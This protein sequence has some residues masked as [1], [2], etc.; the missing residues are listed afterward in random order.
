M[1]ASPQPERLQEQVEAASLDDS[2]L[3][4]NREL[5]LLEFQKRVLEE[6]Q[7]PRLPLLERLKFLAIVSSNL[8]EF[9]MV[10][11]AGLLDQVAAGVWEPSSGDLSPAEQL[12]AIRLEI[13]SLLEES[14]K[15]LRDDVIPG[16]DE[17]G[18]RILPYGSLTKTQRDAADAY[19]AEHV[20]PVLTPLAF[21]PS[22]PFPHISNLS[23]NLAVVI[24]HPDQSERF[25]RVKVPDTLPQFVRV[26]PKTSKKTSYIWLEELISANLELLFPGTRIIEAHPFHVTRDADIAIQELEADDLLEVIAEGVRQRRFGSVVRLTVHDDM[27]EKILTILKNNLEIHANGVYRLNG[28]LALNRLM[29]LYGIDRPDLKDSPMLPKFPAAFDG[30]DHDE[31]LFAVVAREDILLHHP[32]DSF[33]PLIDF[34]RQAARDPQVL[35]I[36]MTLYRVGKNSPVVEALLEAMQNGKQVAVLVELKARFDEESNISW[37]RALEEEGVHVV[38]GLVGLKIHSKVA[39]VVRQEGNQV[40]RYVHLS[41]GN[42][43]AV[44]ANLYTDLG[45]LTC[46]TELAADVTQL[47]NYLTGY[48]AEHHYRKLLVAPVGL[49]ERLQEMIER[50]ISIQESGGQGHLIFKTNGLADKA[51]MQLLYRA[52]RAGVRCDLLVRGVCCLRPGVPGVSEN[53]RVVSVVGRFLEHSRAY[54]FRNG[55]NEELYIGSADIMRRNLTYRVETVFPILRPDLIRYVRDEVLNTA[56]ADNQ[57]ARVMQPHGGYARVIPLA[58]ELPIDSQA[59]MAQRTRS[60]G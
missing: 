19:F 57:K 56:L 34:L 12:R 58:G 5:S 44:T 45:L 24:R 30:S 36:K 21:D 8:N 31:N 17:A 60:A 48:A 28:P 53:I 6:A 59:L 42:Y 47:F 39:L 10:R 2:A 3:Y 1:A 4:V 43:N 52:S 18:V 35:A 27:P 38:Y 54:Y 51:L 23:L 29:S 11:V 20:F 40:R 15:C 25:A 55:G 46:D 41:T 22:R 32:Y 49:R 9:F 33:Q 7:D 16:L 14:R 50:E 13:E 26:D 37:A